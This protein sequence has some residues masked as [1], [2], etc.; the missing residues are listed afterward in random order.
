[1]GAGQ[2]KTSTNN[3]PANTG[4]PE[5]VSATTNGRSGD[6]STAPA[7][8]VPSKR[9][10]EGEESVPHASKKARLGSPAGQDHGVVRADNPSGNGASASNVR[11]F[12][13]GQGGLVTPA[14]RRKVSDDADLEGRK[15]ARLEGSVPAVPLPDAQP[16]LDLD[17]APTSNDLA[18]DTTG[19]DRSR[20]RS[21]ILLPIPH[22]VEEQRQM[23]EAAE[24]SLRALQHDKAWKKSL[25]KPTGNGWK[26]MG[27][28]LARLS[29]VTRMEDEEPYPV[30]LR[31]CRDG[32]EILGSSRRRKALR[33]DLRMMKY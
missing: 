24:T 14:K 13:A 23:L 20:R 28:G 22:S 5:T 30:Y 27:E 32:W 9:R 6:S 21:N 11:F 7:P 3:A 26:Q 10:F 2:S 33:G 4:R 16:V 12:P 18:V 29:P 17:E 8:T 1:M 31:P 25:S 15:R 19:G